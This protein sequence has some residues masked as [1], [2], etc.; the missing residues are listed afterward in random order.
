[1]VMEAKAK[2]KATPVNLVHRSYWNL[3]G[4]QNNGDILLSEE[5]QILGSGYAHLDDKGTP[6]DYRQLRAI[7]ANINQE[8]QTN[9]TYIEPVYAIAI[10]IF[11]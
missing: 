6:Y 10:N 5:I 7:K 2:E 4:R 11:F 3:G 1:M 9:R 8:F